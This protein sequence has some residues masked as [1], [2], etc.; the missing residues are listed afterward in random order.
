MARGISIRDVT[1]KI[2]NVSDSDVLPVSTGDNQPEV[3]EIGVI[4]N[5]IIEDI[6]FEVE[7]LTNLEIEELLNRNRI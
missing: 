7:S 5:H 2:K 6:D 3:V 1:N 4:K